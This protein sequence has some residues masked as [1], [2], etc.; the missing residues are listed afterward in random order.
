MAEYDVV[1][2][3]AGHNGLAAA[4]VLAKSG[5]K[6]L[7]LESQAAAGGAAKSG[8]L[9]RPGFIHDYYA[10][11]IG[12]F[13]G[14]ALYREFGSEFMKAGFAIDVADQAYGSAFPDGRGLPIYTMAEATEESI[15]SF[16]ERD[17]ATWK[18]LVQ[19]FQEVSPYLFPLLQ[20]PIPS[21]AFGRALF[22]MGRKLGWVRTQE[23]FSTLL[24]SPRQFVESRFESKEMQALLIPWGYHLDFAPDT[25]GGATFPF[26]E[27]MADYVN[28]MAI[29]HGGI[30]RLVDSM[31]SVLN[32]YGGKLLLNTEVSSV[33]VNQGR[34]VGVRTVS[35]D[36]IRAKRAVIANVTPRL[37]FGKLVDANL[38]PTR[39]LAKSKQFRY[40]PGTMMVHLALSAPVPWT[41]GG[42]ERSL[43]VH[44]A[45]YVDDVAMADR[46]SQSGLLPKSPLLVVG[47]QSVWDRTRVPEGS[48]TLWVQVRTVPA[49]PVGD[50]LQQIV[51]RGSW[52]DIKDAYADRVIEKIE[53]YAPGLRSKILAR[54]VFSPT[55]LERDNPNL[56]GGDSVSGSH[57]LDQF[58]LFRP[59]PGWSRYRTPIAGL[60]MV[61]ASTWPGA[62]LN[63]ASGYLAARELLR[64]V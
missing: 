45:P 58:Y 54:V 10:S 31:V 51:P 34:A 43:Y 52:D 17:V 18:S 50:A 27:S 44:I 30:S 49:K 28:G 16:S 9:T 14:S 13:L 26:L 38:F 4:L 56:V 20:L 7:V 46:D 57:H 2:V 48:E 41:A 11:N 12:L 64:T 61:G 15:R 6:V 23:L 36:E 21:W 35:G 5:L 42:L 8:E 24:K 55:D 32:S 33:M 22:R 47:Q 1:V 19:E 37:L 25:A 40:G 62:G 29:A 3:G 39:F 60:W 53:R 59:I 63:A